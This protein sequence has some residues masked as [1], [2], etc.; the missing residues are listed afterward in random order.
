MN[1]SIQEVL[2]MLTEGQEQIFR[3][4]K[5]NL[6]KIRAGKANPSMYRRLWLK[7]MEA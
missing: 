5:Q 4:L 7:P 1:S 3:S 2:S 6:S